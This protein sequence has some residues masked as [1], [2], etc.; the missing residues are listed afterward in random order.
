[1]PTKVEKGG[2]T[3]ATFTQMECNGSV[4]APAALRVNWLK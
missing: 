1:M 4:A 2:T 3:R